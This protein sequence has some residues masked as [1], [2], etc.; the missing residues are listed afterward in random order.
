MAEQRRLLFNLLTP[1]DL[2]HKLK[3][4]CLEVESWHGDIRHGAH[5]DANRITRESL[6]NPTSDDVLFFF[7][8]I[9]TF[10]FEADALEMRSKID[11]ADIHA[12]ALEGM[13]IF[14]TT[15]HLCE[16]NGIDDFTWKDIW[17]P[18]QKRLRA[19]LSGLINFCMYSASRKEHLK[20]QEKHFEELEQTHKAVVSRLDELGRL[21]LI[22]D[23][24]IRD[25]S[26]LI[27]EVEKEITRAQ[28]ELQ[29]AQ[30]LRKE[31][32]GIV[33]EKDAILKIAQDERASQEE[34]HAN[35]RAQIASCKDQIAQNPSSIAQDID[36][37]KLVH[38]EKKAGLEAKV[39]EK[40]SRA[41]RDQVHAT[42]LGILEN[43]EDDQ[44]KYNEAQKYYSDLV[45]TR[46]KSHKEKESL[47]QLRAQRVDEVADLEERMNQ[48]QVDIED[49][50]GAHEEQLL[51]LQERCKE[52][53]GKCE[54]LLGKRSDEQREQHRLRVQLEETESEM[55]AVARTH[56]ISKGELSDH[57]R[58]ILERRTAMSHHYQ[59][60]SQQYESM[61]QQSCIERRVSSAEYGANPI[62]GQRQQ[63]CT[64]QA[65]MS[66]ASPARALHSPAVEG[67]RSPLG[68]RQIGGGSV[69]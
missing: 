31:K 43:Y 16:I 65:I 41:Q 7:K 36:D 18:K 28:D 3:V 55:A 27:I 20:S 50:K 52:A 2:C 53:N 1:K 58:A 56:E 25:Q 61:L 8:L 17:E 24:E 29:A 66:V 49:K 48:V 33:D 40:K 47:H 69:Y 4:I 21:H 11:H 37:L 9:A 23:R 6:T 64:R 62:L 67:N 14:T 63:Q 42:L 22:K 32:D 39:A 54:E 26:P 30:I 13:L 12:E 34:A 38:R 44:N 5:K 60:V 51:Q 15:K 68:R 45:E 10:L 46:R 35:C 59:N 19:I 57:H